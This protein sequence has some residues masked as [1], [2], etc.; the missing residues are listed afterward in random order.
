MA[1]TTR[2]DFV[3]IRYVTELRPKLFGN[4]AFFGHISFDDSIPLSLWGR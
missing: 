4:E 3:S 2:N 1:K